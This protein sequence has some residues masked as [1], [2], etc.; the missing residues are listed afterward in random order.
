MSYSDLPLKGRT[1]LIT[2]AQDKQS[3][4]HKMFEAYGALVLDLPAL[5]IGPPSN[6]EPLDQALLQLNKFD[7]IVFSSSNG[8]DAIEQRLNKIGSSLSRKPLNLKIASIGKKTALRLKSLGAFV[9]FI[10]TDFI[11]ESL[12]NEFPSPAEGLN[13]LL[14]RV[15]TGGRSLLSKAFINSGSI[16]LEVPAYETSC[17]SNIP[18]KTIEALLAGKVDAITFTSGK[19]VSHT[20][21]LLN[22]FVGIQYQ[23]LFKKIHIISIGPQTTLACKRNFGRV[24]KEA[25]SFDL[26]GLIEATVQSLSTTNYC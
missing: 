23:S 17:P 22:K 4:A 18:Q 13:I 7:W 19:T 26:D 3:E 14:P 25:K 11:A 24:D 8:V 9:D 16:V 10:P 6:W 15:E 21:N 5:V 20:V 12:I 2:R 1:I